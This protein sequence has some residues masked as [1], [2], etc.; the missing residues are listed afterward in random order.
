MTT[1]DP[2]KTVWA[3]EARSTVQST[4]RPLQGSAVVVSLK[5]EKAGWRNYLLTCA[6][7][8]KSY[9]SIDKATGPLHSNIIARKPFDGL[10]LWEPGTA[11]PTNEDDAIFTG[12][13][14]DL[15]QRPDGD[16][17]GV[18]VARERDW[19][20]IDIN[21]AKFQSSESAL[22]LNPH[23]TPETFLVVGY[24]DG[25][26]GFKVGQILIPKKSLGLR[27]DRPAH[28]S[29]VYQLDGGDK[30]I[31][32]MSGGGLFDSHG[33]LAGIYFGQ[34]E[35]DETRY[36]VDIRRIV[37]EWDRNKLECQHAKPSHPSEERRDFFILNSGCIISNVPRHDD[38]P[39]PEGNREA[40]PTIVPS[41]W[42]EYRKLIHVR[43]LG[44][45]YLFVFVLCW[46]PSITPVWPQS[47]LL[48]IAT[49][50]ASVGAMM[51]VA[52][53][54][55]RR[56]WKPFW[57][58]VAVAMGLLVPVT[59]YYVNLRQSLVFW[60]T[61]R[62][63]TVGFNNSPESLLE[64]IR[65]FESK[66]TETLLSGFHDPKQIWTEASLA[67]SERMLFG[68]WLLGTMLLGSSVFL[69]VKYARMRWFSSPSSLMG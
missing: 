63:V 57:L 5:Q 49:L 37:L 64:L 46:F 8:V 69:V 43:L 59:L 45:Y 21:E 52:M 58:S 1:I 56:N 19:V 51:T 62:Y 27:H 31:S 23:D 12:K 60:L 10:V 68:T 35:R 53:L 7:V 48:A 29:Y 20:L 11:W 22:I 54:T 38:D 18:H 24:P 40:L 55:F 36:A 50:I 44:L 2:R 13:V 4:E 41:K 61:D 65:D 25:I 26:A 39:P 33:S 6:H 16:W 66:D 14:I 9:V 34:K 28:D 3:I 47:S 17:D 30:T 67:H 15:F 42:E 32:G